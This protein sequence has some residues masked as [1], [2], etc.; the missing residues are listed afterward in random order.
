VVN[1]P[2]I[3]RVVTRIAFEQRSDVRPRTWP[4]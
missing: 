1:R 4:T 2:T 3:R